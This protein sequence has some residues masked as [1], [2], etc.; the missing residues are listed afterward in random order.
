M[1]CYYIE[2]RTRKY[3]KGNEFL[4]FVRNL[5]VTNMG[6]IIE[7][8]YYKKRTRIHK[9]QYC[10]KKCD[11]NINSRNVGEIFFPPKKIHEI[12]NSFKQIL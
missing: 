11:T 7:Y 9:K 2:P 8:Y 12:Q 10:W 4:S 5:L 3:F 6:K 1:T